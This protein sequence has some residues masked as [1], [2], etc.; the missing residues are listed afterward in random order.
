M[1]VILLPDSSKLP[2]SHMINKH[3]GFGGLFRIWDRRN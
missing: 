3:V 1:Y 2:R